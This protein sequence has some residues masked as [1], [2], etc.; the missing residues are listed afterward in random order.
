MATYE[1]AILLPHIKAMTIKGDFVGKIVFDG[2]RVPR[3]G[4]FFINKFG[5]LERSKFT[6]HSSSAQER[7]IVRVVFNILA[8]N[9]VMR[10]IA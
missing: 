6:N 9:P 7:M 1:K 5:E 3:K 10:D 2:I 4:E 8:E